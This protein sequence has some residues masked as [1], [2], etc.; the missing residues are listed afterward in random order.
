MHPQ[1]C[2]QRIPQG[3]IKDE[4]DSCDVILCSPV[5]QPEQVNKF[6]FLTQHRMWQVR[7]KIWTKN[8]I[9]SSLSFMSFKGGWFMCL[10]LLRPCV[11][12][13]MINMLC[14]CVLSATVPDCRASTALFWPLNPNWQTQLWLMEVRVLCKSKQTGQDTHE[15]YTHA[16]MHTH[17]DTGIA[18]LPPRLHIHH[19]LTFSSSIQ[20]SQ[21][22]IHSQFSPLLF[23]Q[24]SF[25]VQRPPR[26][27]DHEAGRQI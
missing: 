11:C 10:L 27:L 4:N 26:R 23:H 24:T 1:S 5:N 25:T 22:S 14:V 19:P 9:L 2:Q 3:G 21:L 13:Y 20:K 17:T 16:H 18:E 7:R 8:F 12:G 6:M 15:Q